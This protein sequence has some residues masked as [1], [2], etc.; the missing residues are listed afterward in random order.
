MA[1]SVEEPP[2]LIFVGTEI[3][4]LCEESIVGTVDPAVLEIWEQGIHT[5][6]AGND[7]YLSLVTE[8]GT[9]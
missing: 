6:K 1:K 3:I 4:S 2:S 5:M 9:K 7:F 8:Y